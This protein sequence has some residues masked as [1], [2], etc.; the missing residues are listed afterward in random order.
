MRERLLKEARGISGLPI[1]T[2]ISGGRKR[3]RDEDDGVPISVPRLLPGL[4]SLIPDV[5]PSP[6]PGLHPSRL[7]KEII[8]IV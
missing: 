5:I 3:S 8:E 7:K 2:G 1:P 4:L 6:R